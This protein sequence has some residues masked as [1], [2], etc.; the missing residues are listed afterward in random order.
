MHG[1]N[2][3]LC[4]GDSANGIKYVKEAEQAQQYPVEYFNGFG[5]HSISL[6]AC[7]LIVDHPAN[8][9][10]IQEHAKITAPKFLLEGCLD[11]SA[12]RKPVEVPQRVV[13]RFG[14]DGEA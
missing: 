13:F 1:I 7:R 9:E 4:H 2:T 3:R 11:C 12:L 5:A 10:L 6:L 14:A 8:A